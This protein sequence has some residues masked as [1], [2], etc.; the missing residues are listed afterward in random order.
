M[1]W[2]SFE[3]AVEVNEVSVRAALGWDEQAI[4]EDLGKLCVTKELWCGSHRKVH[5]NVVSTKQPRVESVWPF[6]GNHFV[7]EVNFAG[8][9][10]FKVWDDSVIYS[11][12]DEFPTIFNKLV[13]EM[14]L[15]LDVDVSNG[16][17]GSFVH[18]PVH[19]VRFVFGSHFE[20]NGHVRDIDSS[21]VEWNNC[22]SLE[23]SINESLEVDP[24]NSYVDVV[25]SG[26]IV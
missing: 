1:W 7:N 3:V 8:E 25:S 4:E 15:H 19:T 11:Q 5:S 22:K 24:G 18:V 20:V 16:D 12:V 2:E 9:K 21:A 6:I 17:L 26:D 23:F 14:A 10:F 13:K